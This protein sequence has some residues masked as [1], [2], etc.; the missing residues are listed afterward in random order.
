[1][2]NENEYYESEF[3]NACYLVS[4]YDKNLQSNY[5]FK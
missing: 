2:E 1:M 5:S 4:S 3:H